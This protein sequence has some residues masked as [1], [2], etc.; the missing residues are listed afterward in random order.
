MQAVL[1]VS[2]CAHTRARVSI[3]AWILTHAVGEWGPGRDRRQ[4][5][6]LVAKSQEGD[7]TCRASKLGSVVCWAAL[8]RPPCDCSPQ[9]HGPSTLALS[10]NS[11]GSAQR[12]QRGRTEATLRPALWEVSPG[13]PQAET[14]TVQAK[15]QLTLSPHKK[16]SSA[17]A[18]G[19]QGTRNKIEGGRSRS[20]PAACLRFWFPRPLAPGADPAVQAHHCPCAAGPGVPGKMCARTHSHEARVFSVMRLHGAGPGGQGA[21]FH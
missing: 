6:D 3:S 5:A 15:C 12:A 4:P 18:P 17:H 2:A 10:M 8:P 1:L 19:H 16:T 11:M 7:A 13:R 9:V 14:P 20:R 21:E